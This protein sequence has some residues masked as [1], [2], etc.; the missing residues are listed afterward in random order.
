MADGAERAQNGLNLH[1]WPRFYVATFSSI[2]I[3]L[4]TNTVPVGV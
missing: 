4:I 2:E 3:M 1:D